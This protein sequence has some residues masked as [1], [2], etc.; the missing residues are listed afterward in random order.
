M[1]ATRRE[2]RRRRLRALLA[3]SLSTAVSL[4]GAELF[5]RAEY[6][7]PI[8]E[9]LPI[10]PV[11]AHPTRGYAATREAAMAAFAKSWRRQ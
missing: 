7:V 8:R 4:A 3:L 9:K 2:R 5:C 6:G 10:L 1:D 11:D